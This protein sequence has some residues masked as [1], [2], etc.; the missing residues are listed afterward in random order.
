MRLQSNARAEH[1][2]SPAC[3]RSWSGLNRLLAGGEISCSLPAI[4]QGA[5]ISTSLDHTSGVPL[6]ARLP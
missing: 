5:V 4:A 3:H 2:S 6:C 1:G